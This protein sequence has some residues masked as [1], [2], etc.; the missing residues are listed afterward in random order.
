MRNSF[1]IV[2]VVL[3]IL[4]LNSPLFAELIL[5]KNGQ[6]L[7]GT[8]IEQDENYVT[9][10]TP[11]RTVR[12]NR[13]EI[14]K[15][16]QTGNVTYSLA[17]AKDYTIVLKNGQ[18][19]K[20]KLVAENKN[21]I[22]IYSGFGF[23]ELKRN[24]ILSM[25]E[26]GESNKQSYHNV[27]AQILLK[28]G[29]V[30]YGTIAEENSTT[31]R[32]ETDSGATQIIHR[33][34]IHTIKP[35][36]EQDT[37]DLDKG[38]SED[39][40]YKSQVDMLKKQM[41]IYQ[42][43]IALLEKDIDQMQAKYDKKEEKLKLRIKELEYKLEKMDTKFSAE[44]FPQLTILQPNEEITV[45]REYV[46]KVKFRISKGFDGY[47]IG[48]EYTLFSEFADILPRFEVFFFNK[49][50]LNIGVDQVDEKFNHVTK[51]REKKITRGISLSI[52]E[53]KPEYFYIKLLK[54]SPYR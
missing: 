44:N 50:G 30:Y 40:F 39:T 25:R 32:I 21:S 1:L 13:V 45:N 34:Q 5:L 47:F 11:L 7:K 14:Y 33:D 17:E 31:I 9:I 38:F 46:I 53:E 3:S 26:G 37:L 42:K 19:Y 49:N 18:V 20:G 4:L 36:K 12:L 43:E 10:Q 6:E 22:K 41:K 51:G 8:V 23:V 35:I 15:M 24:R 54:S 52:P 28:D 16:Q 2:L 29:Q 27:K 48:A